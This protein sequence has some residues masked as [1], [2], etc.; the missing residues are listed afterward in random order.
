MLIDKVV[1]F[2][3]EDYSNSECVGCEL[4]NSCKLDCSNCLDDLHFHR[5]RLRC[6]Y[7]CEHLL[8]YY[9]C[10]YSHKYCSEIIYALETID[11]RKYPFFNVLSLGCG[12]SPDL[13]A[14][15]YLGLSPKTKY[16]GLDIN[17]SLEKVHTFI[18]TQSSVEHIEYHRGY[19]VLEQFENCPITNC[20]TLI[21]EYLISFFYNKIGEEGLC[22]WFEQ[23]VKQIML[24]RA[25]D[26]PMLVIINDADSINVGRDA[27][28][29]L[30]EAI[31]RNGIK[32]LNEVRRRFKS[33][34]HY[35]NS[36]Q[37]YSCANKFHI[38]EGFSEKYKVAIRC[39][40]AQLI[41]EVE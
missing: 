35:L 23:L 3:D 25:K 28:P 13:M 34:D 20:N 5:N 38:P 24:N 37:Y 2:C 6:D 39:E 36:Q 19:D 18:S 1:R 14:F 7:A 16:M 30:R 29:K 40:S 9:V 33:H 27:F 26:S 12:A 11:L 10:R 15:D 4:S 41:L 32:V 31:E 17:D 8:D 22:L 21:I